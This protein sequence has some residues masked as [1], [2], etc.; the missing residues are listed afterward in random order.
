M[1]ILDPSPSP[2]AGR[3]RS[4]FRI[5]AGLCFVSFGTM[6]LF[7]FPP[8]QG[9]PVPL[10]SEIG[11][12]GILELFGGLLITLGLLT[13]PVAFILSG[14]MAVAY[15]QAHFPTSVWPSVNMGTPAILYCFFYLYL[16][17]AGPGDWSLDVALA[18]ARRGVAGA[19][20]PAGA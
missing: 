15:F 2:W 14:E 12:A 19:S 9:M 20:R 1:S 5:V 18:R 6:K 8:Y 3:A 7:G 10:V 4:V 13:K 16:V 11:L 17:F